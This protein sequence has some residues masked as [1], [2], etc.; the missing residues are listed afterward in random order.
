MQ[1][2]AVTSKMFSRRRRCSTQSARFFPPVAVSLFFCGHPSCTN[3]SGSPA[4][5]WSKTRCVNHWI[6]TAVPMTSSAHKQ[7]HSEVKW[8]E[9]DW[10]ERKKTCKS[11]VKSSDFVKSFCC[12]GFNTRNLDSVFGKLHKKKYVII[13]FSLL[14]KIQLNCNQSWNIW[15]REQNR[16]LWLIWVNPTSPS[17]VILHGKM[18]SCEAEHHLPHK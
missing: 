12:C 13:R 1:T 2:P 10:A 11:S 3:Y 6:T 18:I 14:N 9:P 17:W 8:T 15:Y 7:A 5:E 4:A 16:P